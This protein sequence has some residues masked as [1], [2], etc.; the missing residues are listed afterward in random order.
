MCR[1]RAH[2]G[3][4][5]GKIA[6]LPCAVRVC[7]HPDPAGQRPYVSES[8]VPKTCCFPLLSQVSFGRPS[9]RLPCLQ[10][11]PP[12]AWASVI[13]YAVLHP[14]AEAAAAAAA[15][16]AGN[17]GRPSLP[18]VLGPYDQAVAVRV[19]I[20]FRVQSSVCERS[21]GNLDLQLGLW[22]MG[23]M[24]FSVCSCHMCISMCSCDHRRVLPS[25]G[26]WVTMMC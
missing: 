22:H 25:F 26:L 3:A 18:P 5:S 17:T 12:Y 11:L 2:H 13:V 14:K 9:R 19:G 6:C 8:C 16:R 24:R 1:K 21:Y 23:L 10:L 7:L 15:A 4:D 20:G